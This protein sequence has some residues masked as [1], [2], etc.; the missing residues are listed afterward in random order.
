MFALMATAF[1][2]LS[3]FAQSETITGVVS[4]ESGEPIIGAVV[5]Y[6]GTSVSAITDRDGNY[7]I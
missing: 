4:D 5:Y 3:L 1:V 7:S 2:S 6:D